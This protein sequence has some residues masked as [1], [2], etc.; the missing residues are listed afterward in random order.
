LYRW[1]RP[2]EDR[3]NG[4]TTEHDEDQGWEPRRGAFR[5]PKPFAQG[6]GEST[7]VEENLKVSDAATNA[8][9]DHD[10]DRLGSFHLNSI[11]QRDPHHP[12]GIKGREAICRSREDSPF[13]R[14]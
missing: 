11:I 7:S 12:E 13:G 3:C 5:V 10:L 6:G 14:F 8:K 9:N 1:R 4:Y 2:F